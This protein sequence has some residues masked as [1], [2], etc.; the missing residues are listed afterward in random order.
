M[1]KTFALENEIRKLKLE[2][3]KQELDDKVINLKFIL[4]KKQK[5]LR[6]STIYNTTIQT[7]TESNELDRMNYG[8]SV[9]F[10]NVIGDFEVWHFV[11]LILILWFLLRKFEFSH[12]KIYKLTR[13]IIK[14]SDSHLCVTSI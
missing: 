12:F 9:L 3:L 6:N 7:S 4:E 5:L 2:L 10:L 14:N 8:G 11:L 1:E 13:N